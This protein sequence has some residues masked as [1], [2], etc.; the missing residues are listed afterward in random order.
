MKNIKL[1]TILTLIFVFI[2]SV[3]Y[4]K[5]SNVRVIKNSRDVWK[6]LVNNKPYLVK[7]LEYSAD[8][9]GKGSPDV[10]SWMWSDL[11]NNGKIDGPYDSW[12]DFNRN[13]FQDDIEN[14]V[15]DFALMK[16]MGCNTIRIYHGENVNKELLREL[17]R[18]YKIMVIMG[19]Y[20]GAYTKGS[21]A[22]W[23]TGTDYLDKTQKKNM[24]ENVKKMVEEHKNEPYVLMWMLG[25]ENDS[26]GSTLN[27][28]KTNT[29][30][31]KYPKE[32]AQFVEETCKLIMKL[33]SN[34]PIGV[35]NATTKFLKYYKRYAPDVDIFGINQY[36]GPY[37]FGTLW[38]RVKQEFDKPVLITEYGCDA[39]NTNKNVTCEEY[40]A[41]YHRAAWKNIE[42]NSYWGEGVGNSI[43]GV[44]YCWMDKWWLS[45]SSKEHDI[46]LG[47][48]KGSTIDGLFNDEWLGVCSQGKGKKSPFLRQLRNVYY[49]YQQELWDWDPATF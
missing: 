19:N 42:N 40:Q 31:T 13:N 7:G 49:L 20:L 8:I 16:A 10:N 11:N 33:D 32:Y 25:N 24:L 14:S 15:G 41:K 2:S 9:V 45:G 38:S 23:S 35:C 34:H 27:S 22:D 5:P 47:A 12:I 26:A 48:W 18:K 44:V 36:T 1:F 21:G 37:G 6:L 30:A 39:Y 17:Y 43:G 3:V 4:A 28:T 29:N 46:K